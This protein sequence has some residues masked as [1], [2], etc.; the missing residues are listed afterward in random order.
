MDVEDGHQT[1]LL[2]DDQPQWGFGALDGDDDDGD[3]DMSLATANA[4]DSPAPTA[5]DRGEAGSN[6]PSSAGRRLAEDFDTDSVGNWTNNED[7]GINE[8]FA[9]S[10]DNEYLDTRERRDSDSEV[11]SLMHIPGAD[12]GVTD[13]DEPPVRDINLDD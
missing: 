13:E 4:T 2:S 6:S 11:A 12:Q 7:D 10:A 5:S 3:G 8:I 1:S 9:D